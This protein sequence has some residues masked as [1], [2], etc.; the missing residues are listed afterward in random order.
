MHT[1]QSTQHTPNREIKRG[2]EREPTDLSLLALQQLLF[3]TTLLLLG[4]SSLL[5]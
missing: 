1:H 4:L 5:E 3:L 2:E